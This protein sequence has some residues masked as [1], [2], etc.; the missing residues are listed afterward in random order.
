[1]SVANVQIKRPG[2]IPTQCLIGIE[3]L[4]KVPALGVAVDEGVD[5]IVLT[6]RQKALE[7]VSGGF[8]STPLNDLIERKL[9]LSVGETI[10]TR[11]SSKSDPGGMKSFCGSLL[12][13]A[14]EGRTAWLWN[15]QIEGSV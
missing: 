3:E 6:C 9:T 15:E 1:M 11:R 4:L 13:L 5:R 12:E 10:R 7:T 14:K 8:F 2:A